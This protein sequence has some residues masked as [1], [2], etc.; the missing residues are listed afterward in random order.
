MGKALT[1]FV[2]KITKENLWIYVINS[3]INEPKTGYEIV[4]EVKGKYMIRVTTVSVYVVLYKMERDGLLKSFDKDGK[5][6]YMVTE[7]GLR[8]YNSAIKALVDLLSRFNCVLK[9]GGSTG[10]KP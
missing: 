9:C 4:K 2:S 5:K 1:R 3:L 6:Y 10:E 8:E 7:E